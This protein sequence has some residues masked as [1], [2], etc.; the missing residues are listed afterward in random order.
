MKTSF[1]RLMNRCDTT[2]ERI[3][4][5]EKLFQTEIQREKIMKKRSKNCGIVS[6]NVAHVQLEY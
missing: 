2:E 4:K 1:E 3:R 5:L 6:K